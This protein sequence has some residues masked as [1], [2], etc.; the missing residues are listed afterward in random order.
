MGTL[1]KF[2]RLPKWNS[3]N[4]CHA[5][6]E[7]E[8]ET[9]DIK[10]NAQKFRDYAAECRCLARRSSEKDRKIL[11]EIAD[12]WDACGQEAERKEN[13]PARKDA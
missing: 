8:T 13:S 6:Y 10:R 9:D 4:N 12:A 11:M 3:G 1:P 2:H 5:E 7:M